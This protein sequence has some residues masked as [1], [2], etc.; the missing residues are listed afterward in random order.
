MLEATD[1]KEE[2]ET[3]LSVGIPGLNDILWG[4]LPAGHLYLVDGVPGSGKTTLALQFL[5]AGR[6]SGE[7]VLYVTLSETAQ[8]LKFVAKSHH[9]NLEGIELLELSSFENLL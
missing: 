1:P 8:E 7:K 9:W 4:G 3:R 5:M 6:D 2:T